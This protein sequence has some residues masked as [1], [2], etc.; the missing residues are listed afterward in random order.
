M[1]LDAL[2]KEILDDAKKRSNTVGETAMKEADAIVKGAKA[3][4]DAASAEF[5]RELKDEIGR[6]SL[7][8]RSAREMQERNIRLSAREQLTDAL[9]ERVRGAVIRRIREKGLR[10]LFDSAIAEALKISPMKDLTLVMDKQDAKYAKD[11]TGKVKYE[12]TD[13]L[14]V[15]AA[16]G[17]IKIDAT[18]DTLFDRNR[19]A[20]KE[21]IRGGVFG[22]GGASAAK[23]RYATKKKAAKR[24]AGKR[25]AP[26]TRQKRRRRHK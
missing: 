17:K 4:A 20:V 21:A 6:I 11:F 5:E 12:K 24:K 7:E 10:R 1:P 9:V 18:L 8:Y 23:R 22:T 16:G 19:D 25:A 2:Q 13:G 15:Y 3:K 14:V 26:K